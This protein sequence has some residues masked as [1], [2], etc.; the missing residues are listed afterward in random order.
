MTFMHQGVPIY[1]AK[2]SQEGDALFTGGQD[3]VLRMWNMMK[4]EPHLVAKSADVYNESINIEGHRGPITCMD[5]NS[6]D[7]TLATGSEDNTIKLWK[8]EFGAQGQAADDLTCENLG[9]VGG[10]RQKVNDVAFS[11]DGSRMISC[12]DGT[13]LHVWWGTG[14]THMTN[15][16][17]HTQPSKACAWTKDLWVVSGC[18]DGRMRTWDNRELDDL[19]EATQILQTCMATY[20]DNSSKMIINSFVYT[21]L[22]L[23]QKIN[24]VPTK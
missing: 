6:D 24:F 3:G 15:L 5:V 23:A 16:V 17:G 19:G 7:M 13:N 1:A 11:T 18:Q 9:T 4:V 8:F 2:F 21:P 14:P 12:G 22:P 10:H 20:N